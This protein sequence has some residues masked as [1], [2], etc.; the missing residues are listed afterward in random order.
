MKIPVRYIIELGL[1]NKRGL[2]ALCDKIM[3]VP[4]HHIQLCKSCRMKELDK[5]AIRNIKH[6]SKGK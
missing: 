5:Y 6:K 1:I 2:C 4:D 3:D